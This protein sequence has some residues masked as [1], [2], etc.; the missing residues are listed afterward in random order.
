MCRS[1]P[2]VAM[3]CI[4]NVM[5][6]P[7]RSSDVL[8]DGL[9]LPRQRIAFRILAVILFLVRCVGDVHGGVARTEMALVHDV[10]DLR[11][12]RGENSVVSDTCPRFPEITQI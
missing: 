8:D 12:L 11:D 5:T 7:R 10:A 2:I 9:Q 1:E 4:A 3:L 6:E